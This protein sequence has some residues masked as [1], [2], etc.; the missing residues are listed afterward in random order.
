MQPRPPQIPF[1]SAKPFSG[2]GKRI[3]LGLPYEETETF[4]RGSSSAPS[5]I[6]EFSHSLESYSLI[7]GRD[8]EDLQFEDWGD[9]PLQGLEPEKMVEAVENFLIDNIVPG[10]HI[11]IGGEHTVTLGIVKAFAKLF[12]SLVVVS[13]DAHPDLRHSYEGKEISHATVMRRILEVVGE[14]NLILLGY[15][16]AT[17]QELPLINN[18]ALSSPSP[19]PLPPR[20]KQSPLYI[21]LDI[22]VLD[23]ACAPGTGNPEPGGWSFRDLFF[24]LQSLK[25]YN[26][27]GMDIVEVAPPFDSA[28]ITSV[29]AGKIIREAFLFWG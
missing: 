13:L 22:D 29:S 8:L 19:L 18:L 12:P 27:V 26:V 25:D 5:Y 20:F 4:R 24:F 17:P 11:F 9:L 21:S 14:K 3:L 7:S 23:P 10:F 6:R 15:R 16:T 28:G 1:L 2:E